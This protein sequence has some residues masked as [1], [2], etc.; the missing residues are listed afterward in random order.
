MSV[1]GVG[2]DAVLEAIAE[3]LARGEDVR[4][5]EFRN[6]GTGSRLAR[7]ELNSRTGKSLNVVALIRSPFEIGRP[8]RNAVN[9][10]RL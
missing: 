9:P 6:F 10:G 8:L 4:I 1:P 3:A 2:V 5:L 7:T